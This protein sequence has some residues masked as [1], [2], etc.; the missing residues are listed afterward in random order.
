MLIPGLVMP[1]TGPDD[2][3]RLTVSRQSIAEYPLVLGID[4]ENGDVRSWTEDEAERVGATEFEKQLITGVTAHAHVVADRRLFAFAFNP[5][6]ERDYAALGVAR[7]PLCKGAHVL[8]KLR[9]ESIQRGA[10]MMQK[11]VTA[12]WRLGRAPRKA[13]SDLPMLGKALWVR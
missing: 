8:T 10:Q 9:R 2:D 13:P 11:T 6:W 7:L 3:W 5:Y 1:A 4:V 12:R